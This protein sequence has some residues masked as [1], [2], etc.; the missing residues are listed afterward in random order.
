[1][2]LVLL[3]AGLTSSLWCWSRGYTLLDGDAEAHLNIARRLLDSRTPG[4]EQL[5]TGW[6]PLP[7]ILLVPFTLRDSWW[8]SGIAG[9]VP[10]AAYLSLAGIFLFA[11][12]RRAFQSAAA[13]WAAAFLF[14]LNPNSLYLGAVPMT[15][16]LFAGALAALLWSSL[17]FRDSGSLLAVAAAAIAS[18]AASLTRYEGWFLIPFVAAYFWFSSRRVLPAAV[19]AATASLA[20]LAWLAHN[21]FYYNNPLEF[22][23][24]P[25]SAMAIHNRELAQGVVVPTDHNWVASFRYYLEAARLTAGMPLAVLG[26]AGALVALMRRQWWPLALLLLCPI[27]YIWSLHSGGADLYVPTLWPFTAYNTRYALPALMFAAFAASA[28]ASVFLG[29]PTLAAAVV[30]FA[31]CLGPWLQP[32]P[33]TWKE[34]RDNSEGRRQAQS[35]AAEYL[36]A[37]YRTGSGI[38]MSLGQLSGVL[39]EAGIPLREVLHEGNHPAWDAAMAAPKLFLRE[40]WALAVPGDDVARMLPQAVAQGRLYRLRKQ[41]IVKSTPVVEIYHLDS[42][43]D[44][45]RSSARDRLGHPV[46]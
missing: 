14:A 44:P 35:L 27:F 39:R 37:N 3:A 42:V 30:L 15:E 29:W 40:E 21:A 9:A 23:S 8:R 10:S 46:P 41:V 19:F 33:L 2:F 5:G 13:G 17:W 22:Y 1:V 43:Q 34:A 32:A 4:P 6:L 38:I 20:P 18:N 11:A 45:V 28:L 12:A 31:G 26:L 16:M 24:G 36:A 7:H 25:W